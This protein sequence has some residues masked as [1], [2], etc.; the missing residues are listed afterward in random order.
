MALLLDWGYLSEHSRRDD[1]RNR[2]M[3]T[4]VQMYA[5]WPFVRLP[6]TSDIRLRELKKT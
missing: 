4:R 2:E 5:S 3:S 6:K 1:L